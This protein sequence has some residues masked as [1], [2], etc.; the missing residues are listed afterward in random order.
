MRK[1]SVNIKNNEDQ[2]K[3]K[4]EI[5]KR[6]TFT[7]K[8]RRFWCLWR[9]DKSICLCCRPKKERGDFLFK[10]AKSKLGEETDIL[11]IVKKLRVHHFACQQILKPHQRDLVNFFQD[12]KIDEPKKEGEERK[13]SF[14]NP[15][16]ESRISDDHAIDNVQNFITSMEMNEEEGE[17]DAAD[18]AVSSLYDSISKLDVD[19]PIDRKI[20]TRVT[21]K[22]NVKKASDGRP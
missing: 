9:F 21:K 7:Y 22:K 5:E 17:Q 6:E 4:E 11:E 3:V 1:A 10:S 19:D 16:L 20:I 15:L 8:Y 12:Y 2:D 18:K 13:E 14:V